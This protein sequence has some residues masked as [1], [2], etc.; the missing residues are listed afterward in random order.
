VMA[1][2][3]PGFFTLRGRQFGKHPP[4]WQNTPIHITTQ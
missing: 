2:K 3:A 1:T 4:L